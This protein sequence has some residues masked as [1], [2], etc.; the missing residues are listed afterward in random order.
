MISHMRCFVVTAL[1]SALCVAVASCEPRSARVEF[2]STQE[3]YPFWGQSYGCGYG[4]LADNDVAVLAEIRLVSES[5]QV[6]PGEAA[7]V[8]YSGE[9]LRCL[10]G[11]V[12]PGTPVRVR[13]LV[14]STPYDKVNA[15]MEKAVP[16]SFHIDHGGRRAYLYLPQQY[17][18]SLTSAGVLY[19]DSEPSYTPI[20]WGAEA[21][22]ALT[23]LFSQ[24]Q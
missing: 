5:I 20:F 18:F 3:N 12:E 8:V 24:L 21:D 23:S 6:R 10:R 15:C 13:M 22:A 4:L 17:G 2:A 16:G 14:E 11:S 19:A 1:F 7:E 9:L